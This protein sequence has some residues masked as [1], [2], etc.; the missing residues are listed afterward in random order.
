[1]AKSTALVAFLLVVTTTIL[2]HFF[3]LN[4]NIPRSSSFSTKRSAKSICP[5]ESSYNKEPLSILIWVNYPDGHVTDE[6]LSSCG[7]LNCHVTFDRRLI[8]ESAA[9][10]F[11]ANNIDTMDLLPKI[12]QPHQHF[13]LLL[14]EP[15]PEA[16]K[17]A[18]KAVEKNF[19]TLTMSYRRDSDIFSPYG[20]FRLREK[21]LKTTRAV[22]RRIALSK[23]KILFWIANSCNTSS[24]REVYVQKL[25][26]YMQVDAYGNCGN[27]KCQKANATYEKVHPCEQTLKKDYKFYLAFETSVCEDY[28]TE[29]VFN[30]LDSHLV[31]IVFKRSIAQPL[32]PKGSFIAADDFN[33]PKELADYL[34]YLNKNWEAYIQYYKWKGF[35]EVAPFPKGIHAGMCMLCAK[36][37]TE[38]CY[39]TIQP[40]KNAIDIKQWFVDRSKCVKDF[41]NI[42]TRQN[43]GLF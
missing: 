5:A 3:F 7:Q 10:V 41:G 17:V 37:R 11:Y 19:F 27:L 36:L 8:N 43:K 15:P 20:Y 6:Y 26:Q 12:R 35:Y 39:R 30:L 22:W 34:N 31:P 33:D 14:M 16:S 24:K 18:F 2:I 13:V 28:V 25:K 1:M 29:K 40:S 23:S 38:S 32:L 21:P 42:L 4:E 9:V